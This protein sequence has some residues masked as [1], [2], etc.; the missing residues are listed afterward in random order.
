MEY[1]ELLKTAL[2]ENIYLYIGAIALYTVYQFVRKAEFSKDL[3]S[4]FGAVLLVF[5]PTSIGLILRADLSL[6][7]NH[8]SIAILGAFLLMIAIQ[9]ARNFARAKMMRDADLLQ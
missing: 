6:D 5:H 8:L 2:S 4:I 1:L 9:V 3:F 7:N